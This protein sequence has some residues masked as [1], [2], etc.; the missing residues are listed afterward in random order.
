MFFLQFYTIKNKKNCAPTPEMASAENI[1][2]FTGADNT[3][4]GSDANQ[5]TPEL[6]MKPPT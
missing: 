3:D 4:T 5:E 6:F 2:L 1:Q